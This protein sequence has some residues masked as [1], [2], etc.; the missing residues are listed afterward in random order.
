M[1]DVMSR[2]IARAADSNFA[3]VGS[4]SKTYSMT[5]WRIG[6][7]IAHA[8]LGELTRIISARKA[9]PHERRFYE[10]GL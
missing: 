7:L 4:L 3:I 8:D 10:E 9:T 2:F 1:L 6:Y 5:G